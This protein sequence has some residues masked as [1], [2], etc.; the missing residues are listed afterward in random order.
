MLPVIRRPPASVASSPT[1]S[2]PVASCEPYVTGAC[3]QEDGYRL[4][5]RHKL[6]VRKDVRA[7]RYK[8]T[9]PDK[10]ECGKVASVT[11]WLCLVQLEG[12]RRRVCRE[13][14]IAWHRAK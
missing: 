2:A 4:C 13:G 7:C 11:E 5:E 9:R 14:E 8:C 6:M 3:C 12:G 1:T 10:Q